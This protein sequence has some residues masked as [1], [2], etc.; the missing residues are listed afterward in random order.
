MYHLKVIDNLKEGDYSMHKLQENYRV[1]NAVGEVRLNKLLPEVEYSKVVQ[2]D[3]YT[4]NLRIP[5]TS[6]A[7]VLE[8]SEGKVEV[9]DNIQD[10]KKSFI[11]QIKKKIEE[12]KV[13]EKPEEKD[14]N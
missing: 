14:S 13:K 11:K 7:V 8:I 5:C 6:T 3:N 10:P 4:K 2:F 12:S 9:V 1:I